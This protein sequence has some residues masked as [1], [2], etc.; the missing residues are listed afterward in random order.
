M[1][2]TTTF[3]KLTSVLGDRILS[4]F[5]TIPTGSDWLIGLSVLAVYTLVALLIGI[6]TGFLKWHFQASKLAIIKITITSFFA[7]ALLEELFFR[8]IILPHP[9]EDVDS[10][11]ILLWSVL[12]LFL[13]IIYHPLNGFTFFPTGK[14]T[15]SNLIFLTLAFL[16]CLACS[17]TYLY[18][19]SI[20]IPVVIHWITV[21]VW[22]LFFG[23]IERLQ[24]DEP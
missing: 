16:L 21:V 17:I 2:L 10:E 14:E 23:G 13:F 24:L 9:S 18:A 22:L 19:G 20:S 4:G 6:W 8:A 5:S 3:S 1:N 12:G 7:P 11:K 15:F